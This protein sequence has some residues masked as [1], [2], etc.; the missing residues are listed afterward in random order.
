MVVVL[1][2]IMEGF[3]VPLCMLVDSSLASGQTVLHWRLALLVALTLKSPT[4]MCL[5]LGV[6]FR[7]GG[8]VGA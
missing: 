4:G 7:G 3:G 5:V 8:G 1:I 2:G 6:P